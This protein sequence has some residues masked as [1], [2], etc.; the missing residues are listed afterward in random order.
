MKKGGTRPISIVAGLVLVKMKIKLNKSNI[1]TGKWY[2]G[3]VVNHCVTECKLKVYVELD[4]EPGV[5][6]LYVIPIEKNANSWFGK[7]S[8]EMELLDE[9][10]DVET[11]F[12]DGLAVRVKLRKVENGSL[13]IS[14]II[15]DEEYYQQE[16]DEEDDDE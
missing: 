5:A 9:N 14:N 10:G 8:R 13:F 4:E 11:E 3:V 16:E 6:Y 2:S 7:F 1:K 15:I 12:L